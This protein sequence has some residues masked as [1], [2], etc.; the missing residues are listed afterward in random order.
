[1]LSFSIIVEW[2]LI[3]LSLKMF[4]EDE[5]GNRSKKC[6]ARKFWLGIIFDMYD[7]YELT[8]FLHLGISSHTVQ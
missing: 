4:I 2:A 3:S 8:F 5:K 6:D 7:F 1:M